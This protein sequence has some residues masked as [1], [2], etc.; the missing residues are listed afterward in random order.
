MLGIYFI[1]MQGQYLG[2][3]PSNPEYP[4]LWPTL[5]IAVNLAAPIGL[6]TVGIVRMAIQIDREQ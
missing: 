6:V 4:D 2:F 1:T 3:I 5:Y